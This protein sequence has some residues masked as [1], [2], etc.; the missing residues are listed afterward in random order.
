[1]SATATPRIGLALGGGGAK[2]LA[3]IPMLQTLDRFGIKP[4]SISGTS[5]GAIVGA[6]YAAGATGDEIYEGISELVTPPKSWQE[7][8]DAK[9]LFPWL[10]YL[11]LEFGRGSVLQVDRFLNDLEDVMGVSQFEDLAIPLKVVASDFW[12]REEVVFDSGPIIPAVAASFA[13]PGIFKPVVL[14]DASRGDRVLV[15]GGSVNP[16]PFDLLQDECDVV[17]AIDVMGQRSPEDDLL[18]SF[19][20]TLF[21]TFQ[22]AE[23]SI[24]NAKI[25]HRSPDIFIEVKVQGVQVLDFHKVDQI[26]EQAE[27]ARLQLETA[28]A[29][30]F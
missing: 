17:I 30:F 21:N 8:M 10:D 26:F 4:T 19:S 23:K 2:G 11:D 25:K 20:E 15:D 18:P 27:S 5:I 12:L 1:M 29:E 9:R 13:L 6:L 14:S 16:L 7:A 24:L 22:I 3:H 28:L